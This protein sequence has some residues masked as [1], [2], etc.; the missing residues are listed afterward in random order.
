MM[1]LLILKDTLES[2]DQII[3]EL[4]Q[5]DGFIDIK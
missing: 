2:I 5:R 1:D 4:V 3:R